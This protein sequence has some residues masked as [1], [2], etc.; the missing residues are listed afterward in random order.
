MASV[1]WPL[2]EITNIHVFM[3]Q[4]EVE[5]MLQFFPSFVLS[6]KS[7]WNS[8]SGATGGWWVPVAVKL[9]LTLNVFFFLSFLIDF[10]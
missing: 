10:Y 9:L 7:G 3:K 1:V 2:F 4:T 8:R 6:L 5:Q